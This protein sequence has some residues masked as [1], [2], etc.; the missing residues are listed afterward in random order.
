MVNRVDID[1]LLARPL[2]RVLA[3]PEPR[4]ALCVKHEDGNR[5]R[6]AGQGRFQAE[7]HGEYKDR[8]CNGQGSPWAMIHERLTIPVTSVR[9]R[10]P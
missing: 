10:A 4:S 3:D 6:Y 9:H 8:L 5:P 2:A 7:N 1:L